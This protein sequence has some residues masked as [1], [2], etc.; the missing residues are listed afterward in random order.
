MSKR[1]N[2]ANEGRIADTVTF[3]D[4]EPNTK[5]SSMVSR[6]TGSSVKKGEVCIIDGMQKDGDGFKIR[7]KDYSESL[8]S[9][10]NE[11]ENA[12]RGLKGS[13]EAQL[14]RRGK[15][16]SVIIE[17][18][19]SNKLVVWAYYLG[20]IHVREVFR[21]PRTLI[22]NKLRV[23]ALYLGALNCNHVFGPRTVYDGNKLRV[24]A[25]YLASLHIREVF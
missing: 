2:G 16:N 24:Y 22:T 11:M 1:N 12:K 7:R 14:S 25:Y 23:Y 15:R 4:D 8:G 13:A 6:K 21:E 10:W 19:K 3:G 20:C 18:S 17:E 5:R 9:F